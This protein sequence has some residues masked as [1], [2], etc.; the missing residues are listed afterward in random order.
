MI[1]KITFTAKFSA[2]TRRKL[3]MLAANQDLNMTQYL[4][5]IID[6]NYKKTFDK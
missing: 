5:N 4:I 1:Q 2:D 3:H 6:E